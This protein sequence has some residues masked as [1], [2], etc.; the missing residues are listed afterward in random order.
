LKPF[1]ASFSVMFF[2]SSVAIFGESPLFDEIFEAIGLSGSGAGVAVALGVVALGFV[3]VV[4]VV[5]ECFGLPCVVVFGDDAVV[6]F[7]PPCVADWEPWL[8]GATV[9]FG[10]PFGPPAFG[11]AARAGGAVKA[12]MVATLIESSRSRMLVCLR[13]SEGQLKCQKNDPAN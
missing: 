13:A 12:M 7:G 3:A 5:V 10:P 11:D 8:F 4:V 2:G 6:V 1:E 9:A